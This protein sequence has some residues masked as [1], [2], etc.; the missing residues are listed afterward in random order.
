MLHDSAN[1]SSSLEEKKFN[2]PDKSHSLS[3]DFSAKALNMSQ[4][5]SLLQNAEGLLQ[6]NQIKEALKLYEHSTIFHFNSVINIKKKGLNQAE[7]LMNKEDFKE[8]FQ[9]TIK[10]LNLISLKLMNRKNSS[11]GF[12]I[13]SAGH[14][15]NLQKTIRKADDCL[16]SYNIKEALQTYDIGN[17]F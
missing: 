16:K 2:P 12:E 14:Q 4:F 9:R 3:Y 11:E 17:I 8:F 15:N 5:Q 6:K 13:L 1:S 7:G 10:E